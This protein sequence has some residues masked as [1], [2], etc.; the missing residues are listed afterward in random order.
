[1]FAE[2]D[3]PLLQVLV[4]A[5]YSSMGIFYGAAQERDT[6]GF[7]LDIT[8]EGTTQ[9]TLVRPSPTLGNHARCGLI[10]WECSGDGSK[11]AAG[12]NGEKRSRAS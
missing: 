10:P 9:L 11:L 4:G 2:L 8:R 5:N 7:A 6:A 3:L 1:M 12:A